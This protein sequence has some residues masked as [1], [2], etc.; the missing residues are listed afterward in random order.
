MCETNHRKRWHGWVGR[1]LPLRVRQ[2]WG[3][4]LQPESLPPYQ[5][6]LA[7]PPP[8]TTSTPSNPIP[9]P[10]PRTAR[11]EFFV[12]FNRPM[13]QQR[14][15]AQG[16]RSSNSGDASSRR[17]SLPSYSFAAHHAHLRASSS[18]SSSSVVISGC[19]TLPSTQSSD[20][21]IFD[22][23][24]DGHDQSGAAY[25]SRTVYQEPALE[26]SVARGDAQDGHASLRAPE[27]H[28]AQQAMNRSSGNTESEGGTRMSATSS[29]TAML[30]RGGRAQLDVG[31]LLELFFCEGY[32]IAVLTPLAFRSLLCLVR[33]QTSTKC[34]GHRRSAF[35]GCER[36]AFNIYA[37]IDAWQCSL[38]Y[39]SRT[40][41]R[42][43]G[44]E[45]AWLY[46]VSKSFS[47]SIQNPLRALASIS[48]LPLSLWIFNKRVRLCDLSMSFSGFFIKW[49]APHQHT[50]PLTP[51]PE[52][53]P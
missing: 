52:M 47:R 13:L 41:K 8:Y 16:L 27:E 18:G 38:R 15:H 33:R 6:C 9:I 49:K 22:M 3:N 7:S 30:L 31:E 40:R 42:L 53:F 32:G 20:S 5:P 50:S 48:R 1:L 21:L 23:S 10:T 11:Q 34:L 51:G 4:D 46:A 12:D 14:A 43:K 26:T 35:A 45:Q 25:A 2:T 17:D 44:N 39:R 28:C 37:A 29:G 19:S 24:L 36:S